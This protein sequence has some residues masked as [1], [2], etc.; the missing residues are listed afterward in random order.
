MFMFE[1]AL[2]G[3][4]KYWIW[5]G[6]LLALIFLGFLAYLRQAAVGLVVTGLTS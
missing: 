3:S 4:R 6:I 5:N 1:K 2:V